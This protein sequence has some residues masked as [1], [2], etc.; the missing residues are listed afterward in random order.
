MKNIDA[1]VFVLDQRPNQIDGKLHNV[2]PHSRRH[3]R[4]VLKNGK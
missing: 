4:C 3:S 1:D 2:I